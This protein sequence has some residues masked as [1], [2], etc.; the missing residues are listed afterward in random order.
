M[1]THPA[2]LPRLA[3]V[4]APQLPPDP[5]LPAAALRAEPA[6]RGF[7]VPRQVLKQSV[8]VQPGRLPLVR[9]AAPGCPE[10]H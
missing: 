7:P 4:L 6:H 9:E 3:A 2:C 5:L 1:P 10:I 8:R